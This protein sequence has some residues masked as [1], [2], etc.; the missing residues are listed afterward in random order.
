MKPYGKE[1]ILDLHHC[2]VDSFTRGVIRA[3]CRGLCQAI[4]MQPCDL[5]FFDDEDVAIAEQQTSPQT[6]GTSAVQ[7]ILTSNITIHTLD[8]LGAVYVNIFSCKD[9]DVEVA[10]LETLRWFGGH[11]AKKRVVKR[12]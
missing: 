2:K 1:L 6:K 7:F 10:V 11:V 3:Y 8:L 9:F 5:H 4:D 12:L